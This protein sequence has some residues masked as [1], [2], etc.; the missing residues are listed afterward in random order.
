MIYIGFNRT[1]IQIVVSVW[2]DDLYKFLF[3]KRKGGLHVMDNRKKVSSHTCF[4]DNM[5]GVHYPN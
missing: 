1:N 2:R 5:T 4:F 3:D